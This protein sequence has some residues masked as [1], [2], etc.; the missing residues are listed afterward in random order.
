MILAVCAL[1]IAFHAGLMPLLPISKK[2]RVLYREI[3]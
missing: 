1:D 2:S 3:T